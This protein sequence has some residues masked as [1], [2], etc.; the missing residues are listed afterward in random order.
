M[1]AAVRHVDLLL[2]VH[3]EF[4]GVVSA[5]EHQAD[6]EV[7]LAVFAVLEEEQDVRGVAL[8]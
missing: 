7:Q 6:R 5:V 4:G 1:V 3:V 8:A 2:L